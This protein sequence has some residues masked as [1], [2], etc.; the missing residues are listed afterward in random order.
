[1]LR[2]VMEG[3]V[4]GLGPNRAWAWCQAMAA[5]LAVSL[6]TGRGDEPAGE[7]MLAMAPA[8]AKGS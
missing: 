2:Q 6:L 5:V 4:D 3:H 1:M 8:A 7:D